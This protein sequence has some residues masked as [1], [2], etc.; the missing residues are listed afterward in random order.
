MDHKNQVVVIG[1][2]GKEPKFSYISNGVTYYKGMIDVPR[3]SGNVDRLPIVFPQMIVEGQKPLSGRTIRVWGE[4]KTHNRK[5]GDRMTLVVEIHADRVEAARD[6]V[7][8]NHVELS[9]V[10]CRTPTYRVTPFGREISDMVLAINRPDGRRSYI[11]CIAWGDTARFVKMMDKGDLLSL[12]GR[13]QSREY[14]KRFDDG[15]SVKRTTYE[16]S[17]VRLLM[18]EDGGNGEED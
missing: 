15:S 16:V 6:D 1:T 12:V 3:L 7:E 4:I 9:G 5:V 18:D 14:V 10:L 8:K 11:P 17:I 2:L 13:M